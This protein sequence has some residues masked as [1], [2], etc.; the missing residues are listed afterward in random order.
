MGAFFW[1]GQKENGQQAIV[2]F[3]N[4]LSVVRSPLSVVRSPLSVVLQISIAVWQ[5]VV[6]FFGVV[7]N[8]FYNVYFE[9]RCFSTFFSTA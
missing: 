4:P 8:V 7:Q 5:N 1:G 6:F 3:H 9:E 2:P